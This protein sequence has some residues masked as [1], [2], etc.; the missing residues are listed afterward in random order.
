[1]ISGERIKDIRTNVLRESQEA[2][3]RRVGVNQATIHR[4][5]TDGPPTHGPVQ[6]ALKQVLAD[7]GAG[8]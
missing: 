3:A 1:M 8:Q 2:F 7:V 5:E 4:W 6:M